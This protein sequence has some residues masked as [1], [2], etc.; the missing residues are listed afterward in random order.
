MDEFVMDASKGPRPSVMGATTGWK[1]GTI[2]ANDFPLTEMN[3]LPA[4]SMLNLDPMSK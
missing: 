1:S 4:R 3:T 2:S